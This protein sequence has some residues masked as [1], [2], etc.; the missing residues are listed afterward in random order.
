M[1]SI[2]DL[3]K[4]FDQGATF[5]VK[6]L[7]L[8]INQGELLVLLGPSGCGKTTTLKMLNRLIEPSSGGIEIGGKDVRSLDPVKLR[9]EI[10]Y[11]FQGIGLFPHMTIAENIGIVPRLLGWSRSATLNGW[12]DMEGQL[13]EPIDLLKREDFR[14][15]GTF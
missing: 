1:I 15:V 12:V 4:T 5:A 8:R 11:I 10:G 6:G 13:A 9:R 3:S 7:N 14:E 2:D